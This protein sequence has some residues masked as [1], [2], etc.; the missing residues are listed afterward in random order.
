MAIFDTPDYEALRGR[1]QEAFFDPSNHDWN[2]NHV[3][4]E[5]DR[6]L[7]GA[8]GTFSNMFRQL[9]GR[10][11]DESEQNQLFDYIGRDVRGFGS[12]FGQGTTNDLLRDFVNTNFQRQAEDQVNR[13]LQG[14]QAE[15]T[16]LADLFRSQGNAAIDS[17]Q[18]SLL[19]YQQRLFEK[20]RPQLITSLQ[21]QGLLNTGGLNEAIAG[22]QGD[23]AAA[24]SEELRAMR[25]ANEQQANAIAFGGASAPYEF[26]RAQALNRVPYLQSLGQG[27][28]DR[29]FQN[30]MQQNAYQNQLNLLREQAAIQSQNQPSFLKQV[31]GQL[32]GNLLSTFVPG[33]SGQMGQSMYRRAGGGGMPMGSSLSSFGGTERYA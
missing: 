3:M 30:S 33:V 27:A 20:L 28:I 6:Q 18:N 10:D 19:D 11:P 13:E 21:T 26:Q 7:R 23:L 29:T 5:S 31:G 14:Q 17:T 16:R 9:V 2:V 12:S 25:L 4:P 8:M 32:V 22:A 15:A 1:Y 24:G